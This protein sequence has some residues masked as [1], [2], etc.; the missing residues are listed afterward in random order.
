MF[1]IEY[2]K[3]IYQIIKLKIII[4]YKH[5][6]QIYNIVI[7]SIIYISDYYVITK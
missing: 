6:P 7:K 2:D 1:V 3:A 4:P 5:I